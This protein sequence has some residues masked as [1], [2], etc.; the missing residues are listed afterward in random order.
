MPSVQWGEDLAKAYDTTSAAMYDP[1]VLDPAVD[2]LLSLCSGG[3][4]LEFAVG[5]G[6]V[7]LPLSDRGVEV[8]GIELSPHMAAELRAKDPAASVA[9]TI[10]DM[11]T[12]SVGRTFD[13]VYLVWNS[14]M[15]VT[16]QA[17]QVAVFVNAARHLEPGGAFVLELMVPELRGVTSE[18][19]RRVFTLEP[20]HVGIETF[21]DPVGQISW[22]HHW[23]QVDGQLVRHS[24]PYR[25]IWP[26]EL[27]LMGQ[28]AGFALR[29]R[30]ADW[31][32]SPFISTSGRQVAVF[33]KK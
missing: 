10:G 11:T 33:E 5:T 26:A 1:A 28:L 22:S 19:S 25:Y 27:D 20:D 4:A 6:R 16:T 31:Q 15:N 23:M 7:A 29:E 9:V 17:E 18:N 13:L 12:T 30:W 21:D 8:S 14:L 2:F 3:A 24:A 32:R